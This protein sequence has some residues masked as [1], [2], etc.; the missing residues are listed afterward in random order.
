MTSKP[1]FSPD[2][3][4]FLEFA[5]SWP[6]LGD[7]FY[8]ANPTENADRFTRYLVLSA[9]ICMW[10]ASGW[11]TRSTQPPWKTPSW[12]PWMKIRDS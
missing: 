3:V 6:E 2:R 8:L 7:P 4:Q 12:P 11:T 10:T 5:V 1:E 9:P